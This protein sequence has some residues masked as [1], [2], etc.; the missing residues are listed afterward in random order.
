M[1]SEKVKRLLLEFLRDITIFPADDLGEKYD[2][3][4]S[5]LSGKLSNLFK[6]KEEVYEYLDFVLKEIDELNRFFSKKEGGRKVPYSSLF[7]FANKN[8]RISKFAFEK[9]AEKKASESSGFKR[10]VDIAGFDSEED[11][12][13]DQVVTI[14]KDDVYGLIYSSSKNHFLFSA[15]AGK[16]IVQSLS[17]KISSY[18]DYARK[19]KEKHKKFI[20]LKVI[21]YS[22]IRK[23]KANESSVAFKSFYEKK[24][25]E[26]K[27][28]KNA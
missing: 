7:F 26:K 28:K 15:A 24:L 10:G 12:G 16:T 2:D 8:E 9:G 22:I 21:Y 17:G 20:K 27:N 5:E 19:Q 25:K 1:K 11:N 6:K 23:N 18:L 4:L 3:I 13:D 14:Y